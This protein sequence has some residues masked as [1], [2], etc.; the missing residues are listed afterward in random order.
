MLIH[1]SLRLLIS[2]LLVLGLG[3][4]S[5]ATKDHQ[6]DGSAV[7]CLAAADTVTWTNG[8][9]TIMD[10][11]CTPCHSTY[12]TYATVAR[13]ISSIS[14]S[15]DKGRMPKSP[16]TMTDAQKKTFKAWVTAGMVEVSCSK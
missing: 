9:K 5:D 15:I 16:Q 13:E 6:A 11:S 8:I 3:S 14:D 7:S 10:G 4:C 12:S 2:M 1:L